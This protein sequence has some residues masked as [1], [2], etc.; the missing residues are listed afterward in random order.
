[1]WNNQGEK[2]NPN[3]MK[4]LLHEARGEAVLDCGAARCV[5]GVDALADLQ[6]ELLKEGGSIRIKVDERHRVRFGDH[7]TLTTIGRVYVP[8]R[9]V[10]VNVEIA[11][12]VLPDSPMP[13]LLSKDVF[14]DMEMITD[15]GM[16]QVTTPQLREA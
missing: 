13:I 10:G 7:K 4:R 3:H 8:W 9:H 1:M 5:A 14:K 6:A 15:L 11:I 16:N 2:K 12:G